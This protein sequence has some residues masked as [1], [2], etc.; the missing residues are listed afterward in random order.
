MKTRKPS[1][2]RFPNKVS[3]EKLRIGIFL[4]FF[5]TQK[6]QYN[7]DIKQLVVSFLNTTTYPELAFI[8]PSG[9]CLL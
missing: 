7:C 5:Y 1:D 6:V 2:S 3:E 8:I 9:E 4:F